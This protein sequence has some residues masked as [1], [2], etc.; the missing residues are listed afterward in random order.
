VNPA[1]SANSTVTSRWPA[2][3]SSRY[4]ALNRSSY[5]SDHEAAAIAAKLIAISM[6]HSHQLSCQ[7]V[8]KDATATTSASASNANANATASESRDRRRLQ[9]R[10]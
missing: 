2:S 5:H 10:K 3:V 9:T 4:S 1:R 8:D 6:C 7:D